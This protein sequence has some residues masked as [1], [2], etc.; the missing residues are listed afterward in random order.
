MSRAASSKPGAK[1]DFVIS[2][3]PEHDHPRLKKIFDDIDQRNIDL[4]FI[5][6]QG[7]NFNEHFNDAFQQL[8]AQGYDAA[9][10]VG[11]DQPQMTT[12]NIMQ[13]FHWLDRFQQSHNKGL[14][15]CPCQACGVSLVGLTKDTP[16]D[17]DG[18]FYNEAG[19]SA[20]D[21]IIDICNDKEIPVAAL[22]TVA[23]IDNVEDL[24]HALSLAHSQS[25]TAQFQPEVVVPQRFI[26]WAKNTGLTVTT[27]PNTDHD[28]RELIDA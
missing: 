9:V 28:P 5:A 6:D 18:V 2:A 1:Y 10:A 23:D 26:N 16:M 21:A 11:G 4:K 22:E 14:V 8:W 15:H 7:Q 20:L 3:T 12:A 24:A 17:F 27:P 13:A 19:V 25:Y